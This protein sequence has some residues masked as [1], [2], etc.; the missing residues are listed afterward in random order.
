LLE[1]DPGIAT[2]M[3]WGLPR[4]ADAEPEAAAEL[5]DAL[6]HAAP[7]FIAEDLIESRAELGN[8]ASSAPERC[9]AALAA[10]FDHDGAAAE[11]DVVALAKRLRL[12]LVDARPRGSA[13]DGARPDLSVRAALE[14]A[15][16]AFVTMGSREAYARALVAVERASDAVAV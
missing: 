15:V 2:A 14:N 8:L 6:A 7:L 5:L 4:A 11:E 9:A 10:A 13:G 3:L 16:D 1:R 12:H